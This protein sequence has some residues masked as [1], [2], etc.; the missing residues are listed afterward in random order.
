VGLTMRPVCAA[1]VITFTYCDAVCAGSWT[2]QASYYK[3]FRAST[4]SGTHAGARTAAHRFLPFGT[5]LKVTNIRNG[6]FTQVVVV[7]RGPFTRAR[8]IDVSASAAET[9]GGGGGS[10]LFVPE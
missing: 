6:K 5:H 1:L 8:L 3:Y 2:G 4:S 9:L 7:D 10:L